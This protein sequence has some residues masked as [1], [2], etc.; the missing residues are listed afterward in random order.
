MFVLNPDQAG[1]AGRSTAGGA[2]QQVWFFG[3]IVLLGVALHGAHWF[4]AAGEE[5]QLRSP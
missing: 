4:F 5:K 1:G 3:Q 2:S